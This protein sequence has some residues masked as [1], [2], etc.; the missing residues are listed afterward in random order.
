MTTPARLQESTDLSLQLL[1]RPCQWLRCH[2]RDEAVRYDVTRLVAAAGF[3]FYS[4][5]SG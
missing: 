5:Y 2:A 3:R 1:R 4:Y